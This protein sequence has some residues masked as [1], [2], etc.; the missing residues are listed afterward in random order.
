MKLSSILAALGVDST[1]TLV[2]LLL[3]DDAGD[4]SLTLENLVFLAQV[5]PARMTTSS[6]LVFPV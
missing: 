1:M 3:P 6:Q 4:D 2:L 5:D